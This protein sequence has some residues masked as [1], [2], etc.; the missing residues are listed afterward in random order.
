MISLNRLLKAMLQNKASDL[1]LTTGCSPSFRV[2]GRLVRTKLDSLKPLDVKELCYSILTEKQKAKLENERQIDLSFG[3]KD[4]ARFRANIFF[5]RG[6]I[7]GA[8]RHIPF[9]IPKLSTLGLPEVIRELS[10]KPK[11]LVLITGATGSGKTTTLSS[12][13]DYL[14]DQENLHILTIEDPIEYIHSHRRCVINQRELG[15]DAL[16]FGGALKA[17][18]REDPD[19]VLVGEMRDQET[20]ET[21][22]T[23]AE[24]GHL[25]FSTLHTSGAYQTITRIVQ[26]FPPDQQDHIR[27]QLSLTLEGVVSQNLI[28]KKDMKG[29]V[30][31]VEIMIPNTSI[32]SL[33]RE[34][35]LHQV[36]SAML[37]G[38]EQTGMI[39]MNQSLATL[40]YRDLI[41]QGE[42]ISN[43]AD[44]TELLKML[45]DIDRKAS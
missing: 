13:I 8:F 25:V 2:N 6:A 5:Q 35:K 3:I 37:I 23:L 45:K 41:S 24:T 9:D 4:L 28:P 36:P 42:A 26:S 18:L 38:Q 19:I 43:S 16:T 20:I 14:N 34:N 12:M 40:V 31:A 17:S 44:P 15:S 27:I 39:T 1:H 7:A 11:G 10:H 32:R 30:A 29:R 21:A 22:L 33:I